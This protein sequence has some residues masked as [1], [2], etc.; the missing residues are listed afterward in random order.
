[1][2]AATNQNL[3]IPYRRP[4]LYPKQQA[5]IFGGD[6]YGIIEGSTKCGKT[7]GCLA[8]LL[9]QAMAGREAQSFW[10]VAPVYPQAKIAFRRL[11]RGLPVTLFDSN[12]SEL[13]VTLVN[14]AVIAFRSAE[15]PDNL[16][17][18]DVHAA[19]LDEAT[20]MREEAWHAVRTTLTATRGPLRIIGNVKGRRNWAYKLARRAEAG[21]PQWAYAKLTADDAIEANVV[22]AAEIDEAR[23]QLPEAVFRELYY[24]EPADDTGNPFGATFL[25]ACLLP[26]A[27]AWGS[28]VG[29]GTPVVW[30]WDLAKSVDWTVGV[31]LTN[32]GDVCRLERFQR[33]WQET[34][35]AVRHHTGDVPAL[36]DSTGVGDAVL[37]QLQRPIVDGHPTFTGRNFEGQKFTATSKQQ[38][39]EQLAIAVQHNHIRFPDGILYTELMQFEYVYTRTGTRYDAPEGAHDDCVDALALAVSHWRHPPQRWGAV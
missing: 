25:A 4:S 11:K 20:R 35:Q 21:E 12:E 13:T 17:G 22:D 2:P 7:V 34:M 16:Y 1:V 18:E 27:S 29:P 37:E 31:G 14:G 15:K 19:V 23:S 10:W 39:M 5:A 26:D 36:V 33:P 30:G 6:R 32:E 9:E 38:L 8:W 24:A 28:W 3:R